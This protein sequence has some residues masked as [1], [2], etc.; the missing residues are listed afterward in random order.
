MKK[1]LL[2]LTIFVLLLPAAC[3]KAVPA[4]ETP[5]PTETPVPAE[6]PVPTA[7]PT[8]FEAPETITLPRLTLTSNAGKTEALLDTA[9]WTCRNSKG[10]EVST[11]KIP[12]SR[13][14]NFRDTDWYDLDSPILYADGE[15]SLSFDMSEPKDPK[16][17][18]FSSLGM[19][20]VAL[21]DWSFTPYAG[22][23]TY[24]L[25][26][27]WD[28]TKE[29]GSG[30]CRFI[31]LVE[32]AE[33]NAPAGTERED[34]RLTVTSA[35]AYGCTFTLENLGTRWPYQAQP[36]TDRGDPFALLR[37]TEAGGWEWV[38]PIRTFQGGHAENLGSGETWDWAW[39]WSHS[40][41][42]LPSG[43]Y[44]LML[45]GYTRNQ[46]AGKETL[47]LRGEFT[48]TDAEPAIPGPLT[49]CEMPEGMEAAME[50]RSEHRWVQT[51]STEEQGW[52]AEYDYSLFRLSGDGT[53]E[54]IPPKYHL[55]FGLN[56]PYWLLNGG[57]RAYDVDLAAQY[58][59]LPAGTYV[60]RR[61]FLLRSEEERNYDARD[62]LWPLQ[63]ED[64]VVYGDTLFTLRISLW[65]VPREVDAADE[66]YT[67]YTGE[68]TNLLVS[69]AG[70]VFSSTEATLRLENVAANSWYQVGYESDY[71]YL[72]FNYLGEWFPVAGKRS[73]THG[74]LAGSVARG[75]TQELSFSFELWYG[76]LPP[77]TYRMVISASTDPM[78][79]AAREAPYRI[80]SQFKINADGSGE[81]QG[82]EEAE[83]LVDT[84]S[85][86]LAARYRYDLEGDWFYVPGPTGSRD[87]SVYTWKLERQRDQLTVTVYRDLDYDRAMAL[88]GNHPN[89][90]IIRGES[91]T[92]PSPVR[93]ANTRT[94]GVLTAR[95]IE[96][97]DPALEPAGTWLLSLTWNGEE[98][99][100]LEPNAFYTVFVEE[101]DPEAEEWRRLSH[102]WGHIG[103]QW[104]EFIPLEPGKTVNVYTV[105]LGLYR[106]DLSRDKQYR[107]ALLTD[108][109]A[110]PGETLEYF[111]CPFR[112]E[113]YEKSATEEEIEALGQDYPLMADYIPL[114]DGSLLGKPLEYCFS[115]LVENENYDF[116]Y[117]EAE[118]LGKWPK[119]EN[120]I[121]KALRFRVRDILC[122]A[123][124]ALP[125][126]Y[127]EEDR[128]SVICYS[129]AED[130]WAPDIQTLP[131]FRE[132]DRYILCL[133][134]PKTEQYAW[135]DYPNAIFLLGNGEVYYVT[136]GD[137]I[138][139]TQS[140]REEYAGYARKTFKRL[141]RELYEE[142]VSRQEDKNGSVRGEM[143]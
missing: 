119:S 138:M 69:T 134:L 45:F 75:E 96:Q 135:R 129:A 117:A 103:P 104:M 53:L 38:K 97:E 140:F 87:L 40:Y 114:T 17:F 14:E 111:L 54:Y 11:E 4:A 72:Y 142:A 20:P 8:P 31:L 57:S 3:G 41:G 88:L 116:F 70:S 86:E 118:F 66:W 52:M 132:G 29:A 5:G 130:S 21:E 95:V 39:D 9:H 106:G 83:N 35:D 56:Y 22:V 84:Y 58:G 46:G 44:A 100:E 48:L 94:D 121:H 26:C 98:P 112:L 127:L 92:A 125:W 78:G 79:A 141:L 71:Y 59:Q 77:G 122:G 93:E 47:F 128:S 123:V 109:Q 34:L 37:R 143:A 18:A 42:T 76:E 43:D 32:G 81:W 33:H 82:L 115:R 126:E 85:R 13:T 12:L 51:L 65:D 15:V 2:L 73:R 55:P 23:N 91:F 7:V 61:R 105:N 67:L 113:Q 50:Q 90:E 19:L 74:L 108:T 6:A 27:T 102:D 25:T 28:W 136:E 10:E 124:E 49:L 30:S 16:L 137:L 64:R 24:V 68:E 60:L 139:P 63:P 99:L 131:D 80:V 1:A 36:M 62:R 120:T 133:A 107:F 89:V 110:G 101:Y